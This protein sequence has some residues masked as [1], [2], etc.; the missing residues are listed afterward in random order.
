MASPIRY[1]LSKSFK[2][3]S[4]P[5]Q[6]RAFTSSKLRHAPPFFNLG[7]TA[8]A[9]ETQYFSKLSGHG[10]VNHSPA[11]E[12]IKNSEV[13]PFKKVVSPEP[14]TGDKIGTKDCQPYIVHKP[15]W[16]IHESE[17]TKQPEVEAQV[18]ASATELGPAHQKITDNAEERLAYLKFRLQELK[19]RWNENRRDVRIGD[20]VDE[21]VRETN[22][23]IDRL[24][25]QLQSFNKAS[26]ERD[27]LIAEKEEQQSID[28]SNDPV[29]M[30][31]QRIDEGPQAASVKKRPR[32]GDDLHE[33]Y[34]TELEAAV[35]LLGAKSDTAIAKFRYFEKLRKDDKA[36]RQEMGDAEAG[37]LGRWLATS[38]LFGTFSGLIWWGYSEVSKMTNK[39]AESREA[40]KDSNDWLRPWMPEHAETKPRKDPRKGQWTEIHYLGSPNPLPQR[41][42]RNINDMIVPEIKTTGPVKVSYLP[43]GR[44]D[45][46]SLLIQYMT[47]SK[48]DKDRISADMLMQ[49]FKS[50]EGC[51]AIQVDSPLRHW[52]NSWMWVDGGHVGRVGPQAKKESNEESLENLEKR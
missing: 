33:A 51:L 23:S 30:K 49:M 13:E 3:Q 52:L 7:A 6:R 50:T 28:T 31:E 20:S 37:I 8:A 9:K 47:D 36:T 42:S 26:F 10:V 24:G 44:A 1:S 5:S 29:V 48:K 43:T 14:T 11:L 39:A 34:L 32:F 45:E 21:I 19:E 38:I 16:W 41:R 17:R 35:A 2:L 18:V 22:R 25:T 12:A 15:Q 27:E 40:R 4:L 46:H